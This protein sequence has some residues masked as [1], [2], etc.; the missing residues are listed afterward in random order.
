[1]QQKT[2]YSTSVQDD[3]DSNETIELFYG[4]TPEPTYIQTGRLYNIPLSYL[5]TVNKKVN[6]TSIFSLLRLAIKRG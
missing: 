1:M 3:I 2:T 4:H 5:C 6:K